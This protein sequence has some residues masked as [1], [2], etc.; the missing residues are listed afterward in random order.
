MKT[1]KAE[2]I[3]TTTSARDFLSSLDVS[4]GDVMIEQDGQPRM[5]LVSP[6]M[7]EQQRRAKA[8]LFQS[9]GRIRQRNPELDSEQVMQELEHLSAG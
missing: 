4:N 3:P 1:I 9:I 2:E 6:R 7:L 5:V 8:R